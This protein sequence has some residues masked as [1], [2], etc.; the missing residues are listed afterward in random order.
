[1]LA[2]RSRKTLMYCLLIVACAMSARFLCAE[3]QLHTVD[4]MR[5]LRK[6]EDVQTSDRAEPVVLVAPRGGSASGQVV[7]TGDSLSQSR[8]EVGVLR[9]ADGQQL[10]ASTLTVRYAAR[11]PLANKIKSKNQ[12]SDV[13]GIGE[14]YTNDP[15]Y[16]V[17]LDEPS[18]DAKGLLPIWLTA[19]IPADAASGTY[20]GAV[21]VGELVTPITLHV[22]DWAVP[23]GADREV[24]V[25]TIQSPETL[26]D[27]YDVTLWSDAHL[28]LVAKS[29]EYQAKIGNCTLF[30]PLLSNTHL[31]NPYGMVVYRSNDNGN[32]WDFSYM[33]RYLDLYAKK[34]GEPRPLIFYV[35]EP[36]LMGRRGRRP[37][38]VTITTIDADNRA[39]NQRLPLYEKGGYAHVWQALMD[40]L[41]QQV[42]S[43][44][45][46]ERNIVLG[47]AGDQRP[48]LSVVQFFK[49]IAPYARWDIY[50]H[51]RADGAPA[52]DGTY[53][54]DGMEIG[55]YEHP[56]CPAL[57]YSEGE[58]FTGGWDA[59]VRFPIA[60]NPRKFI[61]LYSPPSQYRS[62]AEGVTV[63]MGERD[64][65][66]PWRDTAGFT[67]LGLDAWE[68]G[69]TRSYL[70]NRFPSG[71]WDNMYRDNPRS[72][73][74][75]GPAGP[76]PTVRYE[77]LR[78]GLQE[79]EARI[80]IEKAL[81]ADRISDKLA[82]DCKQL[83]A[84]RLKTRLRAGDFVDSHGA[85]I[86]KVDDRLW[87]L[88]ED[89]QASTRLLYTLAGRASEAL[90]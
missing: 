76:V 71:N 55:L 30:V 25:G 85:N 74:A 51:G 73:L 35:W 39:A 19:E 33:G 17:L 27:T 8:A 50:T 40:G 47:A 15:Y 23:K 20:Y 62:L 88:P 81:Q 3:Q 21:A 2:S 22:C 78:E 14:L 63:S 80:V 59:D 6:P 46:D 87:G 26:A 24:F 52:E 31:G 9:T 77:M 84:S 7:L 79:C 28:A 42:T 61:Y 83:L 90:R 10:P 13:L 66:D 60:S 72:L 11:V 57:R 34:V 75:A 5:E 12:N 16:D 32:E 38:G 68:M 89:W 69:E 70:V 37:A 86:Q 48:P 49:E 64:G 45:W 36:G 67:R 65:R 43:R 4:V 44:G 18:P 29:F 56:Y 41:H 82:T 58:W 1:M 54:V 53:V